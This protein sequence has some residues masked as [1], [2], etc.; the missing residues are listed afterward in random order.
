MIDSVAQLVPKEE[1]DKGHG[2]YTMGLR[3]RLLSK[4]CRSFPFVGS[5][6]CGWTL[7][8]MSF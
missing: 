1:G 6:K 4:F 3:A 5:T 7:V 2:D 8:D